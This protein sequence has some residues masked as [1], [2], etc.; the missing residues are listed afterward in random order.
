MRD[1]ASRRIVA[2]LAAVSIVAGACT[3]LGPTGTSSPGASGHAGSPSA[4]TSE[5]PPL[6]SSAVDELAAAAQGEGML[7]TIGLPHEWCNYAEL[8]ETFKRK[9]ALQINE[10][11]T[12]AAPADQLAAISANRGS[13]G[14]DAPDVIDVGMSFGV[15]AQKD[16][17]VAPYKVTTWDDIP[18]ATKD[19]DGH[20]YGDYFGV[21]AFETNETV[22]RTAPRDWKDLLDATH[23]NQVALAGDP[24]IGLQASATV[25][26]AALANGGSLDDAGPGLA[27][28]KKLKDAGTLLP[29][30]AMPETIDQGTTPITVR[31]TYNALAHRAATNGTPPLDV[32]IPTT[33][34]LGGANVQAIS[35]FAPHPNAARLWMEFLYSDEGQNLMLKGFCL[36][37]RMAALTQGNRIPPELM[38][39]VPDPTGVVFPTV[40]QLD[41]A[42]SLITQR[43]DTVV[44]LDVK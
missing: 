8:L 1:A 35:A 13:P 32:T 10:L 2:L 28:F 27:F 24:R 9:Y 44:G 12:D 23:K 29:T 3:S 38:A 26:A 7:T 5:G 25:F 31:W 6:G 36:P 22:V 21:L 4:A 11:Q 15:Q 30:I 33:G 40:K 37:I 34:R 14:P 20:W 19:P 16:G 42:T 17:L 39:N 41:S 18:A 43:W